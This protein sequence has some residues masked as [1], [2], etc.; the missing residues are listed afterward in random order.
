M[1]KALVLMGLPASGK[2]TFAKGYFNQYNKTS[3]YSRN[4][5]KVKHIDFDDMLNGRYKK[6]TKEEAIRKIMNDKIGIGSCD[7][8]IL[9]GL[10]LT[11]EDV[12]RILHNVDDYDSM[13]KIEI[14]YW[15]P[16]INACLWND[17]YRR[18]DHSEITIRNAR[19]EQPDIEKIK[20][21]FIKSEIYVI[22]PEVIKRPAWKVFADKYKITLNDNDKMGSK[23]DSW[24][25]GG[26][27]QTCWGTGGSVSADAQ[28]TT[29]KAFDSLLEQVCP[30]ISFLQYKK[31]YASCVDIETYGDHDYYGGSTEYSYFECDVE[32]LYDGLTEL[33]LLETIE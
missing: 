19:I 30:N 2:T 16:D 7:E 9:D 22:K 1:K 18:D 26:T 23:S 15:E 13:D 4:S 21:K 11:N 31:L 28:P 14:H 25:L 10:F 33:G 3:H 6:Y 32:S 20:A 29:Y 17:K 24:C 12:M 8:L 5:Y 27:Y